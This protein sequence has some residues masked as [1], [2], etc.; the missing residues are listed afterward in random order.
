MS[1]TGPAVAWLDLSS[2]ASGDMLLG[3]FIGAG[4]PLDVL[5]VA[6][7]PLGLPVTFR[8]EAVQR[9]GLA[10]T[11]VHVD[12]PPSDVPRRWTDV[13]GLL[14]GLP[15]VHLRELASR[16]FAAL[17]AAEGAVHGIPPDQVHF[18]E[19]GALDAIADVVGTCAAFLHLGP[20]RLVASPVALGSGSAATAHGRIPVPGPA[21]LEL[22][23]ASGTPTSGGGSAAMELCTPTGAALV[24]VLADDFGAMPAMTVQRVGTGAGARDLP[25]RS[26]VVRLVL[27]VEIGSQE[28]TVEPAVL[29]EANV[30]DLDPRLWPEV[31]AA[32][33]EAGAADAWLV[34]IVMKKGR[35]A[36]TLSVLAD[37]DEVPSLRE[38]VYRHT[39]TLGLRETPTTKRPLSRDIHHVN[40]DGQTIAV[41]RGVLPGGEVVTAQPEWEH[42][43]AAARALGRPAREVLARA[44]AAARD[45]L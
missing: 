6:L 39:S 36:H 3:A 12:T 20:E 21:V 43:R 28:E 8:S 34:P 45:L 37:P 35:P 9:G 24:T 14:E 40:V 4:V 30:D 29:L 32:L 25:D 10:A 41:K 23:R 26:N 11:R 15:D 13:Q 44:S 27:G 33:L 18:H 2:G 5:S 42:V 17:A 19:V 22:L 38:L 16:V 1:G 7:A 31:L